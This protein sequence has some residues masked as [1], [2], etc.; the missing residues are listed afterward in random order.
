MI[1]YQ[2]AG[3]HVTVPY[4]YPEETIFV[5]TA[6]YKDPEG[7]STI[8]RL[9]ARAAHPDR[10]FVGIHAQND[11]GEESP[12]RDPIAGFSAYVFTCIYTFMYTCMHVFIPFFSI[13]WLSELVVEYVYD[14]CIRYCVACEI[15]LWLGMSQHI[16]ILVIFVHCMFVRTYVRTITV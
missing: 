13:M 12:E 1:K 14:Y 9:Y 15:D 11:G 8:A 16:G 4:G 2:I 7:A 3:K 5:L 10:I 6:S